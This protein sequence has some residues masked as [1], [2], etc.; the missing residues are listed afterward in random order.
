M[1]RRPAAFLRDESPALLLGLGVGLW[2][3]V[4]LTELI[5]E[6]MVAVFETPMPVFGKGEYLVRTMMVFEASLN[7]V[8][9]AL[10]YFAVARLIADAARVRIRPVMGSPRSSSSPA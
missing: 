4:R 6:S 1:R 3:L 2:V 5:H 9:Y 8:G 7:V 10:V